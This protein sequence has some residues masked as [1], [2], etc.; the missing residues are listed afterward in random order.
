MVEVSGN[1]GELPD[2]AASGLSAGLGRDRD[3]K[4]MLFAL[5]EALKEVVAAV[6]ECEEARDTAERRMTRLKEQERCLRQ[7]IREIA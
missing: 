5:K 1:S 2:E 4:I 6:V 3:K 7:L